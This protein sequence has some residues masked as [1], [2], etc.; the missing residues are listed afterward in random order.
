[1]GNGEVDLNKNQYVVVNRLVQNEAINERE[2]HS[3]A[4]G[5]FPS[6]LPIYVEKEKNSVLLKSSIEGMVPLNIY[7]SGI[8]HRKMFLEVIYQLVGIAKQCE[9]NLMNMNNLMLDVD[10]IFL[11][12]RTK[13]VKCIFWP[14]VNNHNPIFISEFFKDIPFRLVFNKHEDHNYVST[15]L[16]YFNDHAPFSIHNFEKVILELMG[17]KEKEITMGNHVTPGSFLETTV[18]GAENLDGTTVLDVDVYE[19]PS[20]PYLIRESNQEKISIDKPSFRIGK[21]KRYCDYFISNN[22][23][24]SRSHAD[25]ITRDERYYIIDN[26]STNKTFVD[27]RVIPVLKEIEI[28]SGTKIRLANEDFVF[29]I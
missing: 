24:I 17:K 1:M 27:Q 19:E 21:E 16:Q 22:Q 6:L 3:I 12:H 11:D 18:L 2:L 23:T 4:N 5:L 10:C 13:A 26:N 14:I 29:Y 25:I 8:V 28:F 20:F 15:Y 9:T 7:F